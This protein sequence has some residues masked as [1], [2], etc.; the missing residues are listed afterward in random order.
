ML[1][2]IC[3]DVIG[4]VYEGHNVKSKQFPLF[5]KGTRFTDDTVLTVA[6]A[7]AILNRKYFGPTIHR[8]SLNYPS[9]GFGS[10][11]KDWFKSKHPR[12]YGSY[13][14]G[15]AMRVSPIGYAFNSIPEIM[16]MAE[17]SSVISHN[18][19]EAIKGAQAI[20]VSIFLARTKKTKSEIK[21]YIERE[22]GY[23]L[24]RTIDSIRPGYKF[25]VSARGSVPESII[26][27]LESNDYEDAIRTAISI[28]GDSDTIASMC[29]GIA[30]A[31]Y[32]TIPADIVDKVRKFLPLNFLSII[33]IFYQKVIK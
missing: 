33:D 20:A 12:P 30:E 13:G 21:S 11:F 28:G 27:F 23:D 14:N 8:Y 32:G 7:D 4:S 5:S 25:D 17:K 31:Y 29:G 3:G 9:A 26:S 15:S 2:V 22:F 6:I 18:H 16:Q 19:P 10:R 24:N 1:G